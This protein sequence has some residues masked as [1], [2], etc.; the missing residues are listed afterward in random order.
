MGC[1]VNYK[2]YVQQQSPSVDLEI[3]GKSLL[4]IRTFYS[5]QD[6]KK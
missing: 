5:A 3:Y 6:I 2:I 4:S 1:I